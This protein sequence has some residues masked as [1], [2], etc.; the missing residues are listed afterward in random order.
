MIRVIFP[1]T[2]GY[3]HSVM[4][5]PSAFFITFLYDR[6]KDS[7]ST[8]LYS[9]IHLLHLMAAFRFPW[10]CWYSSV[11]SCAR[12]LPCVRCYCW[13]NWLTLDLKRAVSS[14]HLYVSP[15]WLSIWDEQF[16]LSINTCL[17]SSF[18]N[19]TRTLSH[20][21]PQSLCKSVSVPP[22]QN[23]FLLGWGSCPIRWTE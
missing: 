6:P 16:S 23:L 4:R 2:F 11:L 18:M 1:T 10:A 9:S 15:D 7:S 14:V 22:P 12:S 3:N 13:Y 17:Q 5:E 20:Y 19:T 21:R 8:W